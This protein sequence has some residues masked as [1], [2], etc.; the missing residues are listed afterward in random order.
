MQ[1]RMGAQ[2]RGRGRVI[3]AA[4][5]ARLALPLLVCLSALA[6]ASPANATFHEMSIREIYPGG[7]DN[8]SY[9]ELQMWA[10]GQEFVATHRLIA[11]NAD[12]SVN[13]EFAFASS[14]AN[15]ANQSTILVA[16]TNYGIVFDERPAPDESDEDLNLSP[17]GGAVCWIEGSPPDCVA[18]GDFEGPLPAHLPP[19]KVGNPASPSGVSPGK[20]LRRSI[21]KG[22]AT[23][24]DAPGVDDSD[25]SATDFSEVEPSPRNNATVPSEIQCNVATIDEGPDLLT[26]QKSAHFTYHS[27]SEDSTFECKLDAAAF[28]AC[29]QS[30]ITYTELGSS[31]HTFQV[32]AKSAAGTG[33]PVSFKWT[34]DTVPPTTEIKAHPVNPSR[35]DSAAF[36]Y[37][38]ESGASFECNLH[39]A[40]EVGAFSSC[41]ASGKA[42]PD[43]E[44]PGPLADGE[45]TF[46]VRA[47]D[48]ASNQGAAAKFSWEV[49]NSLEEEEEEES[50]P[51]TP[52][53]SG[54][55]SQAPPPPSPPAGSGA[56]PQTK[57]LG[58]RVGTTHDRTPTFRF[59]SSSAGTSFQCKLDHGAYKAC[60]S[61][62]TTPSLTFGPHTL[63]VRAVLAGVPDATPVVI[64]FAVTRR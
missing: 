41:L 4:K 64:H 24:L 28:A 10:A 19:L 32:R 52:P 56:T 48:K 29:P 9:V 15:G 31:P 60:R 34:V 33:S 36:T 50:P 57:L 40:G 14:V 49:N 12:G 20:A 54:G 26:N 53:A 3:I 39:P 61:P 42:Y 8:A 17:A 23:L 37:A 46:E 30:G 35:G 62:L 59:R 18:W 2:H 45:W 11:Y 58:R 7:A 47:T 25:D 44:H 51:A 21:A 16:D 13:E 43:A 27:S 63:K 55:S 22:C 1:K 6:Y 5:P 38:S